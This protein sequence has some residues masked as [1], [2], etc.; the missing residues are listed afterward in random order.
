[1]SIDDTVYLSDKRCPECGAHL[2]TN[3]KYV[4]CSY[5]PCHYG[6]VEHVT[7]EEYEA[8]RAAKAEE[9]KA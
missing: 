4:W 8:Q 1:M 6:M 7:I 9:A 3:G 2:L 5:I